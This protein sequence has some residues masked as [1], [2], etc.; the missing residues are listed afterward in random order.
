MRTV[1][2]GADERTITASPYSIVVYGRAFGAA[3]NIHD[4]VNEFLN[5]PGGGLTVRPVEPMLRLLY[6]YEM[7]VPG[8][9]PESF[10]PW[11]SKLPPAAFDQL[12]M[13]AHD[14]WATGILDESVALFFPSFSQENV[15]A[16]EADPTAEG[17][18]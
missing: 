10:E 13:S 1:K 11:V 8:S 3:H 18:A 4:D 5:S 17:A 7:S 9:Q 16:A 14:G 6:T 12:A 15:G 2:V